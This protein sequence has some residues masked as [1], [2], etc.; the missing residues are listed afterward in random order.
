MFKSRDSEKHRLKEEK[1]ALKK[2]LKELNKSI[3]DIFPIVDYEESFFKTTYGYMN[4]YQIQ[5]KEVYSLNEKEQEKHICDFSNFLRL[6]ADDFKI[7]CMQFPVNTY[8]QQENIRKKLKTAT[9]PKHKYFLNKRLNELVF[10]EKHRYNKEF[11][12][13]IFSN[14]L[15]DMKEKEHLLFRLSNESIQINNIDYNKKIKILFKLSNQNSK[16]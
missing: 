4:I 9:H 10:L 11:F 6:Y 8:L 3:I 1:K 13:M 15:K 16:I 7:I 12:I 5:S 2:E 14:N